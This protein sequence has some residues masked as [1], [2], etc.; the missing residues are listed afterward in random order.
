MD[1]ALGQL[2]FEIVAKIVDLIVQR[3]DDLLKIF[4]QPFASINIDLRN[5]FEAKA[6][7]DTFLIGLSVKVQIAKNSTNIL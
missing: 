3:S 1:Y 5:A 4:R 2:P 6:V 7:V